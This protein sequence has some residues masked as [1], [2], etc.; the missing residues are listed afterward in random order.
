[1]SEPTDLRWIINVLADLGA[2]AGVLAVFFWWVT[3]KLV[4]QL[5]KERSEAIA[6]FQNEMTEERKLHRDAIDRIAK[7]QERAIDGL[8]DHIRAN[9]VSVR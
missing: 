3:A 5:Q 2:P 6:A 1:M 8:L 9:H 4:P 7:N